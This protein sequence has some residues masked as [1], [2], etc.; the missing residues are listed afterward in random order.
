MKKIPSKIQAIAQPVA[1]LALLFSVTC[2]S[3]TDQGTGLA[4][5]SLSFVVGDNAALSKSFLDHVQNDTAKVLIRTVKFHHVGDTDSLDFKSEAFVLNLDLTGQLNIVAFQEI[6]EGTYDKITFRIHKLGDGETIDDP[7]FIEGE[8]GNERYSVVVKGLYES[9]P[10]V[11]KSR[12]TTRQRVNLDPGL[13]VSDTTTSVNVT[14]S[15]DLNR[16]FV[17]KDGNPLN[18]TDAGDENDIDDA[19]RRSFRGFED[20]DRDGQ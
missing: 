11:F 4:E 13:A 8:S 10:F 5:A 12:K 16:W 17:D 9:Q 7:D 1:V 18:P 14:L 19:I 2:E 3:P 15:V 20:N 6:P